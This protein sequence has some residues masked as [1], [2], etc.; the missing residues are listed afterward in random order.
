MSFL[1]TETENRGFW[2]N[3]TGTEIA[4][5]LDSLMDFVVT[6]CDLVKGKV[7]GT[8]TTQVQNR[9]FLCAIWQK[10]HSCVFLENNQLLPI[11][12]FTNLIKTLLLLTKKS[13][14]TSILCI[15]SKTDSKIVFFLQ[16]KFVK[17]ETLTSVHS[18]SSAACIS[19]CSVVLCLSLSLSV[20]CVILCS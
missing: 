20:C 5:F 12:G 17:L 10:P 11:V 16:T 1:Q 14:K 19:L 15:F 6:I 13:P 9:R 7:T 2:G 8:T 3:P 4:V 18:T